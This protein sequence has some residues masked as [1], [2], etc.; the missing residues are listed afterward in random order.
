MEIPDYFV[1][2]QKPDYSKDDFSKYPLAND[3]SYFLEDD[4]QT[5]RLIGGYLQDQISIGKKLKVLLAGRFDDY[6]STNIPASDKNYTQIPDTSITSVFLPRLGLI[7]LPKSNISFYGSYTQSFLPQTSNNRKAGGPFPP[8]KGK[9]FEIGYKGDFLNNQLSTMVALYN[10][11]FVN[12]L[13]T[14][15]N[16]PTG[17]RQIPVSGVRSQ[18]IEVSI[19]GQI[20]NFSLISG[21]AYN[22]TKLTENSSIGNK[23]DVYQN[24]PKNVANLWLK[25]NFSAPKLKNLGIGLG[26]RYVGERVGQ[27]SSQDFIFPAYGLLDANISYKIKAFRVDFNLYN[28]TDQRYF[29]GGYYSKVLIPVG[30]P[31]NF[32]LGLNYNF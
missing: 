7:F 25:Y 19:Q 2:W 24:A 1:N 13:T 29:L 21:Y 3:A 6:Y 10:L 11:E 8:Q 23:G 4:K 15:P 31:R 9:Q 20:G 12:V 28:I 32:R 18:G 14:D 30:E 16:D 27:T 26:Y 17:L 22:V 5:Y